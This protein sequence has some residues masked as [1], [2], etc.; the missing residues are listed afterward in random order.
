VRCRPGTPVSNLMKG[1]SNRGPA[2]AVHRHSASQTRVNALMALHRVRDT[3]Y[4]A[5][6]TGVAPARAI[7]AIIFLMIAC[8]NEAWFSATMTKAPGPPITLRL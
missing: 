8:P 4:R 6:N 5:A 1:N 3:H 2:S 7:S